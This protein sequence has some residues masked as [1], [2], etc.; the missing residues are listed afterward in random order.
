[1]IV[2]ISAYKSPLW[3]HWKAVIL[4][5]LFGTTGLAGCEGPGTEST[6]SAV[7]SDSAAAPVEAAETPE[8]EG[9]PR[10]T[11][12]GW[13]PLRIGMT[14][15][16]VTPHKYVADPASYITVWESGPET[17]IHAGGPSIRY[18]EGCL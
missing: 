9:P 5:V 17:H 8:P 13:G 7:P 11:G 4:L 3:G 10:L 15:A 6:D 12:D 18:V 14:K 16:E 2:P 1:M